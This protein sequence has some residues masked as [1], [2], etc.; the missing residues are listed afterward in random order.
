MCGWRASSRPE[1]YTY[2]YAVSRWLYISAIPW[3]CAPRPRFPT[4]PRHTTT[5]YPALLSQLQL[6][7]SRRNIQPFCS[8]IPF[9][10]LFPTTIFSSLFPS[11]ADHSHP[12]PRMCRTS[13]S[14]FSIS[15]CDPTFPRV[16]S[17]AAAVLAGT[18]I[19]SY[20]WISRCLHT[21]EHSCMRNS[22]SLCSSPIADTVYEYAK[23]SAS[24]LSIVRWLSSQS[25]HRR[26]THAGIQ[27]EGE[28]DSS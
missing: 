13:S 14:L 22:F 26:K 12:L 11:P 1:V 19:F 2:R 6:Q 7:T 18:T 27:R 5:H 15:L 20:V 23:S 17:I 3:F 16:V 28:R 25:F 21:P 9:N 4:T 10:P 8:Q 24:S